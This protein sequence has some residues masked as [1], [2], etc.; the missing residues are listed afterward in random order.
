MSTNNSEQRFARW[1]EEVRAG[2][3]VGAR[4]FVL[5]MNLYDYVLAGEAPARLRYFLTRRLRDLGYDPVVYYSLSSGLDLGGPEG[6]TQEA[7]AWFE[8]TTGLPLRGGVAGAARNNDAGANED[9]SANAVLRG[10]TRALRQRERKCAVIVDYA[11]HLAPGGETALQT[12]EALHAIETFHRWSVDDVIRGSANLAFLLAREGFL[13]E[14]VVGTARNIT[15]PLPDQAERLAFLELLNQR[16]ESDPGFA[17][18]SLELKPEHAAFLSAGLRYTD[19]EEISRSAAKDGVSV[20]EERLR[21]RKRKAIEAMAG[22]LLEV[23]DPLPGGFDDLA[24]LGHLKE[25]FRAFRRRIEAGGKDLPRGVLFV[26]VPGTGKSYSVRAIAQELRFNAVELRAVR[27]MYVGESERRLDRVFNVLENLVPVCVFLDEIDQMLGER[28][29]SGDSGVSQR[30]LARTWQF[31]ADDRHRGQILWIGA[32]NA[33]H[34]LDIATLD[35]FGIVVPFLFPTVEEKCALLPKLAQQMGRE[36]EGSVDLPRLLAL[37]SLQRVSARGLADVLTAAA[38]YQDAD[39]YAPDAPLDQ[40]H[41][42]EAALSYEPNVDP[43]VQEYAVL[44]AVRMTTLASLRP[45]NRRLG[46]LDGAPYPWKHRT[47]LRPGAEIPPELAPFLD[48]ATGEVDL[49]RLDQ[50]MAELRH[51]LRFAGSVGGTLGE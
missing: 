47:A 48:G 33:A 44:S 38:L 18:L 11:H 6:A 49:S 29:A 10:L 9:L 14:Q 37:P 24:G 36:I 41:L 17:G 3:R 31:I 43:R 1:N 27:S 32:S 30:M 20:D 26:G 21:V 7:I 8:R 39:G 50:R 13:N 12:P 28:G 22:E 4:L 40:V 5:T 51:E 16:A 34:T 42:E 35:R 19:L 23:L 25:L 45:F 15:V 46:G 2:A